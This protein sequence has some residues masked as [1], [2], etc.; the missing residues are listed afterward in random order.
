MRAFQRITGTIH[1]RHWPELSVGKARQQ[2]AQ[3]GGRGACVQCQR[4]D[5]EEC[6]LAAVEREDVERHWSF[7]RGYQDMPSAMRHRLVG[8]GEI[9]AAHC[10]VDDVGAVA[11][12][13][14]PHDCR[15]IGIRCVDHA[16][17]AMR[18]GERLGAAGDAEHA[19]AAHRG[20]LRGRLTDHAVHRGHEHDVAR[21]RHAGAMK[22][23]LRGDERHAERAGFLQRQCWGLLHDGVPMHDKMGGMGA[24]TG[25]SQIATGAEHFAADQIRRSLRYDARPVAARRAWPHRLRHTSHRR[26]DIA[27]VHAGGAHF[28]QHLVGSAR[29]RIAGFDTQVDI[30]DRF[31]LPLNAQ[32]SHGSPLCRQLRAVCPILAGTVSETRA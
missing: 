1:H 2:F 31:R 25:Y 21:L 7:D 23:L 29:R 9:R 26:G 16:D 11:A 28:Y 8:G 22:A 24:V 19:R 4:V 32:P 10:V 3:Q 6:V 18:V 20:D 27:A 17:W 12:G 5:A 14:V 15:D 30:I 13:L